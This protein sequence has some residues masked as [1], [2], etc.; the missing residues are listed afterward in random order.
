[1]KQLS[2]T[3]ALDVSLYPAYGSEDRRA[4]LCS[5]VGYCIGR[6]STLAREA[7]RWIS[8]MCARE[9][10]VQMFLGDYAEPGCREASWLDPRVVD[11]FPLCASLAELCRTAEVERA[12][13][14]LRTADCRQAWNEAWGRLYRKGIGAETAAAEAC[15]RITG[16]LAEPPIDS[17]LT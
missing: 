7:L 13:W 11:R 12:P 2:P 9:A 1:L 17:I 5:G 15:G 10:G 3:D 8:Y 4:S 14:N 16:V 6:K